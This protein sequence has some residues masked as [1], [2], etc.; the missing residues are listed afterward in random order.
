MQ[1]ATNLKFINAKQA[2][3]IYIYIYI[4]A[5]KN[6]KQKLHKT[7]AAIWFNKTCREKRLKPNYIN[8]RLRRQFDGLLMMGIVMPETCS[9]VSVRKSNK[10]YD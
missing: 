9:A 3:Y 7:I 4:Y 6:I 2:E 1:G 5:Y 8:I 10:F